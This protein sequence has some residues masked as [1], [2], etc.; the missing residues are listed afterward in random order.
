[1][2]SGPKGGTLQYT[3]IFDFYI[4]YN[5]NNILIIIIIII[6]KTTIIH[7]DDVDIHETYVTSTS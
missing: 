5:T 1:M 2:N 6:M 4:T 3:K 7:I